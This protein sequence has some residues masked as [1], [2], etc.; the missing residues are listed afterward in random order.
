MMRCKPYSKISLFL[1]FT[2]LELSVFAQNWTE[3]NV[4]ASIRYDDIFFHNPLSGITINSEGQVLKTND[5]GKTWAE[6][7]NLNQYLRCIEFINEDVGFIGSLD[8]ALYLTNDGGESW[9]NITQQ[10]NTP[11]KIPGI[12]GMSII[13]STVYACGKWSHPG[14]ILKSE[15]AGNTWNFI[16]LDSLSKGLV[17]LEFWD[18]QTG[19]AAG[20]SNIS[21][22]GGAILKTD[23]GGQ[24]WKKVYTSNY[25]NEYVWK[26]QRIKPNVIVGSIQGNPASGALRMVKSED[27]GN[28]WFT[29]ALTDTFYQSQTIGF[30]NEAYGVTGGIDQLF[31]T[32]N[33]G[34]TWQKLNLGASHNRFFKVN[35]S[36]AFLSGEKIYKTTST[37]LN[38]SKQIQ[39]HGQDFRITQLHDIIEIKF[40]LS[41]KSHIQLGITDLTGKEFYLL[42]DN[43]YAKGEHAVE[44]KKQLLN[45]GIYFLFLHSNFGI[46]H[47]SIVITK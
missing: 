40:N 28:T 12:C 3:L 6:S 23:D 32:L 14:Y 22:E 43:F 20:K 37:I 29:I 17:E 21:L 2:F 8:S 7:S 45:S 46:Q 33:S 41:S 4:P 16:N 44:I 10:L 26:L 47:Q 5:G 42:K 39:S 1:L 11:F 35:D 30:L 24:T 31:E 34:K 18:S 19:L 15:N 9:I 38:T 13:D 25:T 36:L 27:D